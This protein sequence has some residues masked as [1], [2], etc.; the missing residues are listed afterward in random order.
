MSEPS[1]KKNFILST[2]YQI[3]LFIVPFI[4]APYVSR[5]LTADGV[6]IYSYTGS[7]Q[8]YFHYSYKTE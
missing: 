6:G 5:V 3:L 8:M 2:A 7:N 1:L 4:T